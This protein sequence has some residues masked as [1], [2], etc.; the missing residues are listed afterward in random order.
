[1]S[2][3]SQAQPIHLMPFGSTIPVSFVVRRLPCHLLFDLSLNPDFWRRLPRF[4]EV[5]ISDRRLSRVMLRPDRFVQETA[6]SS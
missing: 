2:V 4:E 5:A 6:P 3:G 1:M